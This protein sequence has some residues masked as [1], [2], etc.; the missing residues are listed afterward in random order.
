MAVIAAA[1][2]FSADY[3]DWQPHVRGVYT[4]GQPSV[5]DR[6]FTRHFDSLFKL[7]RHVYKYD[8]VP[9]LPPR[10]VG[11]FPH[12]GA[13]FY[14]DGSSGWQATDPPRTTQCR[15]VTEAFLVSLFSF[16]ARRLTFLRSLKLAHSLEDHGPEGYMHASRRSL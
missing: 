6:T 5:G 1:R 7:Y 14:S 8:V 11:E 13:E 12:F 15:L 9:R 2:I 3:L 4:F 10:S 16:V